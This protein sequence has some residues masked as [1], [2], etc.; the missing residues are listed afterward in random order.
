MLS[1]LSQN[2]TVRAASVNF[3]LFV[4]FANHY[5]YNHLEFLLVLCSKTFI[6]Q[7]IR[8]DVEHQTATM[9]RPDS[10][11]TFL[12]NLCLFLLCKY[13]IFLKRSGP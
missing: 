5:I 12:S 2:G 8:L 11:F 1:L 6:V 7:C 4:Q 9:S 10:L 3:S 13:W